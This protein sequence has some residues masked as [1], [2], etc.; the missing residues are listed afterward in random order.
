MTQE[1]KGV[2]LEVRDNLEYLISVYVKVYGDRDSY[3]PLSNAKKAL[4]RL[5]AFLKDIPERPQLCNISSSACDIGKP[6]N[7]FPDKDLIDAAK[8][9]HD[10]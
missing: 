3:V 9:L 4:T 8:L 5:D 1:H 2:L 6:V 10:I 7:Q